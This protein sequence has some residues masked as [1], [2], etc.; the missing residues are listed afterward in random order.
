MSQISTNS[1]KKAIK[2]SLKALL[3]IPAIL[4]LFVVFLSS[5]QFAKTSPFVGIDSASWERFST[6]FSKSSI[7]ACDNYPW[8]ESE[9]LVGDCAGS[10]TVFKGDPATVSS[11]ETCAT[12]CCESDDCVTWQFRKDVGCLHGGDVRIGMEKDGPASWCSDHAPRKWEGQYVM[13]RA[14]GQIVKNKEETGACSLDTWN[15]NEQPGQCFGLG[16]VKKTRKD[17]KS[18][19]LNSARACME[20]CCAEEDCGAWQFQSGLGCFY[21]A[22]MH[23]CIDTSDPTVFEPFVGRRK[24]R[25]SREYVDMKG[26][27]WSQKLE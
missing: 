6:V 12:A 21:H 27:P 9:N 1:T 24:F 14:H 2:V 23:G 26:K 5:K 11:V 7:P 17:D 3:L 13:Q 15:P 10:L 16:D 20:A 4:S 25:S 19:L 22:R 8:K 18:V